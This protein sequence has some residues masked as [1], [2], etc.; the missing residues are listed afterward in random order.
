[1]ETRGCRTWVK[2]HGTCIAVVLLAMCMLLPLHA[3]A[4]ESGAV[5]YPAG[6]P[7]TLV[8]EFPSIPGL[9]GV[10]QTSYTTSKGLYDNDGD[11]I[12]DFEMDAWAETFRLVASY[13]TKFLGANLYSQLVIPVV[14]LENSLTVSTPGGPFEV[15][16]DSDSGL[17]NIIISPLIMNWHKPDSNSYYTIG[18][19]IAT[20]WGASYDADKPVNVA[21]GYSSFIPVLAYRYDVPNGIDLGVRASYL[22]NQENSDTDYDSGDMLCLDL[23]GG[24]NFGKWQVGITGGYTQQL[25]DDEQNGNEIDNHRMK[26]LQLGPSITYMNGPMIIEVNY[27]KG[28]LAENTSKNDSFW[29]NFTL[30]LY[31]PGMGGRH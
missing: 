16:D 3:V 17:G 28:L 18:L 7:G 1:M 21:T 31:V 30:P 12:N 15:F 4:A 14:K 26:L 13:P 25:T 6:S 29:L 2:K 22:I 5:N 10:S 9:F 23:F 24:W 27:Q 8:G 11:K 20:T 19:D